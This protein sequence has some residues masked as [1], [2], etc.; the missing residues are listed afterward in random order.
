MLKKEIHNIF[1]MEM[2]K[3]C[4]VHKNILLALYCVN[5]QTITNKSDQMT[6]NPDVDANN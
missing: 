2:V 6:N 1:E 4:I 5:S 3:K